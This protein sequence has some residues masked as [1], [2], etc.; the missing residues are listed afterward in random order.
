MLK[1]W[2]KV[3]PLYRFQDFECEKTG[4]I[5]NTWSIKESIYGANVFEDLDLLMTYQKNYGFEIYDSKFLTFYDGMNI[6]TYFWDVI[7]EKSNNF[8]LSKDYH[9]YGT[10]KIFAS[11]KTI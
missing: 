5:W 3:A 10:F 8:S 11:F 4:P 1:K 9:S 6:V 2:S 7:L